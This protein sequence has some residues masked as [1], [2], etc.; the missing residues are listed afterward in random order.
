M[1]YIAENIGPL[2]IIALCGCIGYFLGSHVNVVVA[3]IV[4][5]ATATVY[6]TRLP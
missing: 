6:A 1:K 2:S 4:I 5:V 3:V